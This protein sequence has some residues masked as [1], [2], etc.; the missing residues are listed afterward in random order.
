MEPLSLMRMSCIC[1]MHKAWAAARSGSTTSRP[2]ESN[3]CDS[4]ASAKGLPANLAGVVRIRGCFDKGAA[5]AQTA[6]RR[7]DGT[8][9]WLKAVEKVGLWRTA[10]AG[11]QWAKKTIVEHGK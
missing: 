5:T 4:A 1:R 11:W 7:C 8:R 6:N 3:I 2:A 10:R 9:L